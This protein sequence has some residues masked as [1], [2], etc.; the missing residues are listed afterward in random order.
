MCTPRSPET[1]SHEILARVETMTRLRSTSPYPSAALDCSAIHVDPI[2][3][4]PG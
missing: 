2:T 1:I 3:M 4:S